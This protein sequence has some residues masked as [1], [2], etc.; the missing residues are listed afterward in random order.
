MS[1]NNI[2]FKK[3][4]TEKKY[5]EIIDRIELNKDHK[6]SAGLLNLLG[7]CKLLLKD[8]YKYDIYKA[9]QNFKEAYELEKNSKIGLDSLINFI[10]TSADIFNDNTDPKKH[11]LLEE[12]K[13]Y[14]KEAEINFGFN[15]KLILAI[16]RI[17]KRQN[18]LNN[19]IFYLKKLIDNNRISSK[20]LSSYIYRNCFLNNWSQKD[21][22][23]YSK[24]FNK[25]LNN[26]SKE[27]LSQ[28][29]KVNKEKINIAFLTSDIKNNHSI[30]YFLKPILQYYNK[31]E[32]K[33]SIISNSKEKDETT[34]FF[35]K[36]VDEYLEI[37]Q[38]KDIEALT[39]IRQRNFDIVFDLMGITSTNRIVLFKNRIAPIQIS[40][41]GYCNTTGLN[42]M[43]YIFAD[44]K[45]IRKNEE[46]LYSEKV[47]YFSKI[48]NCHSGFELKRIKNSAPSLKKN[49]I[50]FGSFNNFNKLNENVANIWSQIL[51]EVK[52]S[53]LILKSSVFMQTDLIKSIFKK[54]GVLD[55]V[56]IEEKKSFSEHLNLYNSVD[57]ALDTF[58][59]NGVTTSF[60][61][62]WMGVPVL[63]MKGY[64]FNSRCG[65]SI[66]RNIGLDYLIANNE[67]DYIAKAIQLSNDQEFLKITR[68]KVFNNALS[69]PLFDTEIFAKEF[70]STLEMIYN[71]K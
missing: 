30:T 31:S 26:Y 19:T 24:L 48:W 50:T 69:S 60:E 23:N 17:Y 62:I 6:R 25:I 64:N 14:F 54:N 20:V 66:N 44:T 42:E 4:F 61:S 34:N 71:S 46:N 40:W 27:N 58:P 33:I 21:F 53:K 55:S 51:R 56:H 13:I 35:E 7:V 1:E 57:I 16:V 9:N 29:K 10:N 49:F 52:N 45:T 22:F 36:L 12:S 47:I 67:K 3:L 39:K 70:F 8:N 28:L 37:N 5:S 11:I 38:L 15:E 59:Y 18:D 63:T 43:D 32:F 68:E 41:L 2:D 65:E